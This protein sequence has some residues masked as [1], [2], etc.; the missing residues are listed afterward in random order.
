MIRLPIRIRSAMESDQTAIAT[1][2]H[3]ERLNPFDLDWRR[4]VVASDAS[5]IVGA[6]QLRQHFDGSRELGS[7]VVCRS[8]RSLG[9]A[10][11]LIDALLLRQ[12]GRV[13]MITG[14]R[15][16]AHYARWGFHRISPFDAS[17]AVLGNYWLGR[18]AGIQNLLTGRKPKT[19]AVL[20]RSALATV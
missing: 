6:A 20:R 5:G 4:F 2:V 7:L 12:R 10:S 15:Y 11:R 14:S 1:L 18:I 16:A 17:L 9:I 19:L 13:F 3:T 8:A